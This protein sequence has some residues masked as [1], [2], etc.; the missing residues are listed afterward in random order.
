MSQLSGGPDG[1]QSRTFM[2]FR[3]GWEMS[4]NSKTKK[5]VGFLMHPSTPEDITCFLRGQRFKIAFPF[6]PF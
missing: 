4:S 3:V 2:G 1:L 6:R 5:K